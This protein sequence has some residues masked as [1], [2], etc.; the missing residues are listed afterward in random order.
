[1]FTP[2]PEFLSLKEK[3]ERNKYDSKTKGQ[4]RLL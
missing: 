1:M 2:K 3:K 4:R